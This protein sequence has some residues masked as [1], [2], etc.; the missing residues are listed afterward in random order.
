MKNAVQPS[1]EELQRFVGG[2]EDWEL[3]DNKLCKNYQFKDFKVAFNFMT[4]MAVVA[5][6]IN[7][8]P[9]WENSYNKVSIKLFTHHT[10][11][12]TEGD[13]ELARAADKIAS[14]LLKST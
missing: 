12:V 2:A 7:H 11:T 6:D 14:K 3:K 1:E 10:G 4:Q 5:E 9:T 13:L 8:H